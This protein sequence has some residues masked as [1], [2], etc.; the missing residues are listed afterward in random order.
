MKRIFNIAITCAAAWLAAGC[1]PDA[2]IRAHAG[3]TTDK[4]EYRTGDLVTI[5]N[6]AS[7]DNAEIAVCKWEYMGQTLYDL[8]APEPF[9]VDEGGDFL[10]RQTVT[11]NRGSQ[12]DVF[13][14][15]IRVIDDNTPPVADFT[16]KV[17]GVEQAEIQA[18]QEV[19]FIDRSTDPDEDGAIVAWEWS[20][21]GDIKSFTEAAEAASVKYTFQSH[22]KIEVKLTVTDNRRAKTTKSV[23][24]DV[25][26]SPTSM[27]LWWSYPYD[28]NGTVQGSSP[29]VSPDGQ[30]VYVLSSGYHLVGVKAGSEGGTESCNIN[31]NPDAYTADPFTLT[32]SVDE[33]GTVYA[34]GYKKIDDADHSA[35]YI[36]Q[37]GKTLRTA[38]AGSIN[39]NEHYFFGSPAILNYNGRK[40]VIIAVKNITNNNENM[41]GGSAHAQ[42]FDPTSGTGVVGLHANSGSYGS[43]VALKSG[44]IL[45]S[46]GGDYGTRIY[47]PT[48]DSWAFNR[49]ESSNDNTGNLGANSN[50]IA[51]YGSSIAV[52]KDG[53]TVYIVGMKRDKSS[54]TI[55]CYDVSTI[56]ASPN[57]IKPSPLWTK[58]LKGTV[59]A[60][61]Q[62]GGVVIGEDGT[63]Y[64][65]SC[66]PGYITAISADGSQ[67]L[68]EHAATGDINGTPALG[69][70]NAVYYND[71]SAGNLV[72][73]D[74]ETGEQLV[75]FHLADNLNSSPT[76]GPDG[77]IYCNG[78]LNGKP[79]LFAVDATSTAP[80]DSWSQMAGSPSKSA[81]LY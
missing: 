74:A 16:W 6:T 67:V 44:I 3:F 27:G 56:L 58:D 45:A 18:D 19:E 49:P 41:N 9:Y 5:T 29:A 60:K 22:G 30:Y 24:I 38:D 36:I 32:P 25:A 31:L 79:T 47:L 7:A 21:G 69:N 54:A 70:D 68:W 39:K 51:Q 50:R 10:I 26:K 34:V 17:N 11:T 66:A 4:E 46:G 71:C 28:T 35:L 52:G 73:L 64:A 55:Q 33:D 81:C 1:T 12:K 53:K 8:G 48:G 77:V 43:P 80:A 2:E 40:Y 23:T 63:V 42:I 14:K 76:I 61:K 20:F 15:T 72:K 75:S 65:S 78:V 57:T 59:V 13:E 37:N 62:A